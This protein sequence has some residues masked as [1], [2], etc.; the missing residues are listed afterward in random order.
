M[1]PALVAKL[2]ARMLLFGVGTVAMSFGAL[3]FVWYVFME[4][5][6]QNDRSFWPYL[7]LAL[8]GWVVVLSACVP[9][10]WPSFDGVAEDFWTP[11]DST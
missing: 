9:W 10:R 7:W 4:M 2:T 3:E 6:P 11:T 5:D 1:A 8:A